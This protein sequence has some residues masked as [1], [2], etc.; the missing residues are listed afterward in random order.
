MIVTQISATLFILA[1]VISF[2]AAQYVDFDNRK[3]SMI[4]YIGATAMTVSLISGVVSFLAW[5][6]GL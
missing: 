2:V 6:W 1:A 5:I 3:F 4:D